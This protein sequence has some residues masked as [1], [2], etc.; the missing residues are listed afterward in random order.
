MKAHNF[1]SVAGHY[2]AGTIGSKEMTAAL[3]DLEP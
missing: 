3:A 2:I 1:R